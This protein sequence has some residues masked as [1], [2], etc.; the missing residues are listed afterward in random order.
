MIYQASIGYVH[1]SSC[2]II[3]NCRWQKD[4]QHSQEYGLKIIFINEK[5]I[6]VEDH[7]P[8]GIYGVLD[9]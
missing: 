3:K 4:F 7:K 2:K 8:D 5:A 9:P 6:L 1:K